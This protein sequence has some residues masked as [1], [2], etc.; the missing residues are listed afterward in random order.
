MG[1]V[2]SDNRCRFLDL[3]ALA[4]ASHLRFSTRQVIEGSYSG[5]HRSHRQG[6]SGEFVDYREYAP[7]EDLRRLDWKILGR[8]GRPYVRQYQDETNLVCTAC[9]DVSGSMGFAGYGR[10]RGPAGGQS[11]LEF[12]QYFT[13]A[14]AYLIA[15]QQDQVGL[16]VAGEQL[17]SYL[18]PGSTSQHLGTLYETLERLRPAG[19]GGL[20]G[21][22]SDLFQ[23]VRQRGVLLV[24]SDFLVE[25]PEKLFAA[26][27]LFRH[28]HWEVV[29]LHV[30]HPGEERLPDGLAFR[31]IGLE[32]EGVT[33]CTPAD[34][35][36]LYQ[37][38]FAAHAAVVRTLAL[39]AGC[40]YRRVSTADGYLAALGGFL[41]ERAG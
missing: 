25:D 38:R 39:A 14:L 41:V 12:L 18:E 35:Q 29:V 2:V 31:F 30:V 27:R 22:V 3:R 8:T 21:A 17:Q 15:G 1:E 4:A 37:D 24:M 5:R 13:A 34:V 26:I 40:D 7:G 20:A 6:G 16:A 23:R 10:G 19:V 11:K 32:G 33:D 36:A 9:L 28:R